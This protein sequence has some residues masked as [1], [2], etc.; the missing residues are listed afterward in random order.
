[1]A[2]VK[3]RSGRKPTPTV[4]KLREVAAGKRRQL[5]KEEINHNEPKPKVSKK[6]PSPPSYL[7]PV[8]KRYWKKKAKE[9]YPIGLLTDADLTMFEQ[10]ALAYSDWKK[11]VIEKAKGYWVADPTKPTI[12]K[13]GEEVA[14]PMVN[15]YIRIEVIEQ[16]KLARLEV[17]FGM[18]PSSR[19][20]AGVSLPSGGAGENPN[21]KPNS[22]WVGMLPS[23][24]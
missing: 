14:Q 4:V 12:L 19:A 13:D 7:P 8:A 6:I 20:R 2:G 17:E 15:P 3:G 9:L 11:A 22:K 23:V 10:C 21:N 5:G 24:G 16:K 18:S 1:M